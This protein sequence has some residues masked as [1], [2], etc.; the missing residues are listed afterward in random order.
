[1]KATER[2]ELNECAEQA[3]GAIATLS[4]VAIAHDIAITSLQ[5]T[6]RDQSSQLGDH[7]QAL[8][9]RLR[10]TTRLSEDMRHANERIDNLTAT[11]TEMEARL[12]AAE[13]AC[14]EHMNQFSDTP[15]VRDLAAMEHRMPSASDHTALETRVAL[16]EA[17]LA[18]AE[19]RTTAATQQARV[20]TSKW[21]ETEF[22]VAEIRRA[23]QRCLASVADLWRELAAKT[24]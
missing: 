1:M 12:G 5:D 19:D 10:E 9:S 11:R 13:E 23:S 24:R 17:R 4:T 15:T 16:L 20:A 21:E 22:S 6:R 2:A 7:G 8:A 18:A 3:G 14:A